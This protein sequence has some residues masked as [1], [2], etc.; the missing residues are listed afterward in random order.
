M[1]MD[2]CLCGCPFTKFDEK[3]GFAE[4]HDSKEKP[5]CFLLSPVS[6][7]LA[8]SGFVK[9]KICSVHYMTSS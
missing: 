8:L 6:E 1:V 2:E 5:G 9:R 7:L 3:E 4:S